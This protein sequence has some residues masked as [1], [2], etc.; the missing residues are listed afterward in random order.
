MWHAHDVAGQSDTVL[1]CSTGALGLVDHHPTA[2]P[3]RFACDNRPVPRG[4]PHRPG[5][6]Q[7]DVL[8]DRGRGNQR[9]V[10]SGT[11][12]LSLRP[13][14]S[15]ATPASADHRLAAYNRLTA[16]TGRVCRLAGSDIMGVRRAKRTNG[17]SIQWPICRLQNINCCRSGKTSRRTRTSTRTS[18]AECVSRPPA[19]RTAFGSNKPSASPG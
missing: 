15:P 11:A 13:I 6:G 16:Y 4:R 10:R 1:H 5:E 2:Q 18:I 8:S 17:G 9:D 19:I 12:A 7:L 3:R 14:G